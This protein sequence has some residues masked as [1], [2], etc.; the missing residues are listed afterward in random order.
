MKKRLVYTVLSGVL[1]GGVFLNTGFTARAEM[2]EYTPIGEPLGEGPVSG[3]W[4]D[5]CYIVTYADGAEAIKT[6]VSGGKYPCPKMPTKYA[7]RTVEDSRF[8]SRYGTEAFDRKREMEDAA[9]E[10]RT[11]TDSSAASKEKNNS[12]NTAQSNKSVQEKAREEEQKK[13]ANEIMNKAANSILE[14]VTQ[15]A[16]KKDAVKKSKK[17]VAKKVTSKI[18]KEKKN[19]GFFSNAC[20]AVGGFF[21]GIGRFFKD[22]F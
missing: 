1:L 10:G 9:E 7:P 15:V 8:M 4:D 12:N 11:Y 3:R 14:Q 2:L 6:Y 20:H 19:K 22:I 21:G 5:G 18:D 16:K 13:A 17:E